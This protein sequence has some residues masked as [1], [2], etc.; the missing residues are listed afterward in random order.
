MNVYVGAKM[1]DG[2][3][4]LIRPLATLRRLLLTL[5]RWYE[6]ILR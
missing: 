4:L 1:K 6:H 3:L 5:I 2:I